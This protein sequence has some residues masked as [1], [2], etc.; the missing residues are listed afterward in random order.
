MPFY[1]YPFLVPFASIFL[2]GVS[3]LLGVLIFRIIGFKKD[4]PIIQM[5]LVLSIG[6]SAFILISYILARFYLTSWMIVTVFALLIVGFL[7]IYY[8]DK[9]KDKRIQFVLA[10]FFSRK[11]IIPIILVAVILTAFYIDFSNIMWLPVAEDAK[12]HAFNTALII[13]NQKIPESTFPVGDRP[14]GKL[15]GYPLGF[16]SIGA[17]MTLIF[18]DYPPLLLL[19]ISFVIMA[20]SILLFFSIA[21][22]FTRSITLSVIAVLLLFSVPGENWSDIYANLFEEKNIDKSGLYHPT[23]RILEDGRTIDK[24]PT[25]F[26]SIHRGVLPLNLGIFLLLTFV[27]LFIFGFKKNTSSIRKLTIYGTVISVLFFS[28][29][30][31]LPMVLFFIIF[32]YIVFDFNKLIKINSFKNMKKHKIIWFGLFSAILLSGAFLISDLILASGYEALKFISMEDLYNHHLIKMGSIFPSSYYSFD[33]FKYAQS[34]MGGNFEGRLLNPK[35]LPQFLDYFSTKLLFNVGILIG[36]TFCSIWF[37]TIRKMRGLG[38]F[39]LIIIIISLA[40]LS[41]PFFSKLWYFLPHRILTLLLPFASLVLLIGISRIWDM[42]MK[43]NIDSKIFLHFFKVKNNKLIIGRELKFLVIATIIFFVGPG[44]F[45]IF[46]DS[47]WNLN[48]YLA[49]RMD[50]Q[51]AYRWIAENIP[52]DKLILNSEVTYSAW[53][54][55]FSPKTVVNDRIFNNLNCEKM[56]LFPPPD[57]RENYD[58]SKLNQ[59]LYDPYNYEKSYELIQKYDVEYIFLSEISHLLPSKTEMTGPERQDAFNKNPQLEVVF[60]S[61][62]SVVYKIKR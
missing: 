27:A 25:M 11:S 57:C 47:H 16:H 56:E 30:A 17:L 15:Y 29:Y 52:K 44:I 58:V 5:S 8:H 53:L 10:N 28:Y 7:Y 33:D 46:G 24:Y 61:G 40:S 14:F 36:G 22:F 43:P 35:P 1:D 3:F 9:N 21:Y 41:F 50:D 62:Y 12:T 2:L 55:G 19:S 23:S 59:I 32:H 48:S 4:H 37:V 13:S 26:D 20:L 51:K 54:T 45:L 6:L 38:L 42:K 18:N 39:S 34:V 31:F 60:K 49:P